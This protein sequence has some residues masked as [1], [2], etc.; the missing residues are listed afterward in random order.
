MA[1]PLMPKATAL[2]LI[3][4]TTLTFQQI[5]DFCGLHVLEIQTIADGESNAPSVPFS[6][7]ENQQLS[8]EEIKRCEADANMKLIILKNP[9]PLPDRRRGR[10][11]TPLSKRAERPDGIAWLLH[12]YPQLGD[13]QIVKLVGTTRTTL[14]SVRDRSHRNSANIKPRCPVTLGLCKQSELDTALNE[15]DLQKQKINIGSSN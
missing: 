3:E 13:Q 10:R 14:E 11:Y 9:N 8:H 4:N 7:I 5:A 12:H 1:T 15:A 2:W 6:P